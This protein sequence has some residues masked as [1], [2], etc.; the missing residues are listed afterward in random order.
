MPALGGLDLLREVE[1]GRV[2]ATAARSERVMALRRQAIAHA[3]ERGLVDARACWQFI[4]LDAEPAAEGLLHAGGHEL[5]APRLVPATGRLTGIVCGT[6]TIGRALERDCAALFA[7]RRI[8]LAVALDSVGNELLAAL[9]RRL[10][11]RIVAAV[12]RQGLTLAG[13][14]RAGDPGLA[15]EAQPTVLELAGAAAAG[16]TLTSRLMLDPVKS[17]AFVLGAGIDLP[18]QTWSRCD[19]CRFKARCALHRE[20]A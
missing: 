17:A 7:E 14:L 5:P 15:L 8:A 3:R 1:Q 16:I 19:D 18:R 13:E 6:A 2:P 4:A 12:R 10:Q 9:V 11:D 20:A